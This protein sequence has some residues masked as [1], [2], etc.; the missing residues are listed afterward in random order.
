M[1]EKMAH[2]KRSKKITGII[3]ILCVALIV[4]IIVFFN[5]NQKLYHM[6]LEH[7][8]H[9]VEELSVFVEKNL[10]LEVERHI[11]I[12]Q[13]IE[14]QLEDAETMEG[15]EVIDML[16]KAHDI[17]QFNMMGIS[18]LDGN[19][20]DSVGDRYDISYDGIRKQIQRD[21]VYISNVLKDNHETLS[22][23]VTQSFYRQQPSLF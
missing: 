5:F 21:E 15:Q 20:V 8:M 10:Q 11:H 17:S 13:V 23:K 6:S 22:D 3:L 18:D 19:G 12:L 9:Q 1:D 16:S 7:A 2:F 14:S 4:S